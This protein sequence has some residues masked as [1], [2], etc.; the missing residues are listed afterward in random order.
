MFV[1]LSKTAP[2]DPSRRT[3]LKSL[4]KFAGAASIL[5]QT[6]PLLGSGMVRYAQ[7]RTGQPI[8]IGMGVHRT[9]IGSVYGQWF[10]RTAHAAT[11]LINEQGGINGRELILVTDDDK[12]DPSTSATL[13]D[14]FSQVDKVDLVFGT[15]FS[16]VVT[17]TAERATELKM[18]YLV[19]GETDIMN[20]H[21]SRYVFQPGVT[22]VRSQ[23]IAVA[24][25]IAQNLGKKITLLYPDYAFGYEHRNRLG[26]ALKHF[27]ARVIADI[28][29]PTTASNF[30]LYFKNIPK[31]T[32][33]IYHVMV[34]PYVME[35]V[36]Q[37]GQYF[38]G[39][40]PRLFG[41]IDSIEG[42]NIASPGLE[43]LQGSH[44]WEAYPRYASAQ[45]TQADK[46]FRTRVGVDENG[47]DAS[48]HKQ[49]APL[50]HMFGIWESLF[51]VK[52]A[53]EKSGYKTADR[54]NKKKLIETIEDLFLFNESI[55]HPQ[56]DKIF[57]GKYHQ[58]FGPQY[59]SQVKGNKL[60][61][62]YLTPITDSMYDADIDFRK[63]PL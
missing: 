3:W 55:E 27:G 33:V 61:P 51:V 44:F 1:K 19:C 30:A 4:A 38:H 28:A 29:I 53:M 46:F 41:F 12:T 50:S 56:G 13:I 63:M 21:F 31:E 11:R 5:S 59:I 8:T 36:K 54:A 25:F 9:G 42:V 22:S 17:R 23:I 58:V 15:L 49:V 20:G 10:E 32:D 45:S 35:F 16:H 47:T 39:K 24:P 34:G 7:A 57:V 62:V 18:P 52:E 26:D 40:G 6:P 60:V 43:F 37:M 14:R 48:T 2:S